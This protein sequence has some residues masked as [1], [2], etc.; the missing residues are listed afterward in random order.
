MLQ[1][2]GQA[3]LQSLEVLDAGLGLRHAAVVLQGADGGNEDDAARLQTRHAALDVEELLSTQ[4][5]A[6]AGLG[7]GVIAQVQGDLRSGHGVAAVGDVGKG[8]AVDQR[9][10]MLQRLNQVGLQSVL[11]QSGH[12][13]LCV[14]VTGGDGLAF[15]V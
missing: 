13:A 6:E 12:G 8:A 2:V 15:R 14:Q 7:D 4:I 3:L 1:Q 10:S 5:G 11:Q 9:R